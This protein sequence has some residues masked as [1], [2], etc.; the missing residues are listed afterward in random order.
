LIQYDLA[1]KRLLK[2]CLTIDLA[3]PYNGKAEF[4]IERH[5]GAALSCASIREAS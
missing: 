4:S 3:S 1:D 5:G 2:I